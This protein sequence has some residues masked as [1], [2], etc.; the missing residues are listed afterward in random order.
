MKNKDWKGDGNSI[1]KTLGASNHTDEEREQDDFYA[2]DPD[3]VDKLLMV[4]SPNGRIWECAAGPDIRIYRKNTAPRITRWLQRWCNN[5][6]IY[7]SQ[8]DFMEY[9]PTSNGK[10]IREHLQQGKI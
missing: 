7:E 3:A 9:I 10:T 2:T 1:W 8:K 4:E 5:R 6:F